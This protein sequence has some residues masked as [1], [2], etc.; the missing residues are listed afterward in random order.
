MDIR[1]LTPTLFI[2]DGEPV[3]L[4]DP[5]TFPYLLNRNGVGVQLAQAEGTLIDLSPERPALELG[6][7]YRDIRVWQK[8]IPTL[9]HPIMEFD[10]GTPEVHYQALPATREHAQ[11]FGATLLGNGECIA[12]PYDGLVICDYNYGKWAGYTS[13]YLDNVPSNTLLPLNATDLEYHDFAHVFFSLGPQPLVITVARWRPWAHEIALADLWVKPGD[14]LVIPPK[15]MPLPTP[16]MT[17]GD[18]RNLVVDMHNNRN[19][20]QACRTVEGPPALLTTTILANATVMQAEATR[21]YYHEEK[22]PTDH[23]MLIEL[24][25]SDK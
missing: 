15:R 6:I 19:S 21:P 3:A 14:A 8:T 24:Y 5:T 9:S 25:A 17:P 1:N 13:P 16:G 20:A 12:F 2:A 4:K 10:F 22:H 7:T 11:A 23:T 18:L